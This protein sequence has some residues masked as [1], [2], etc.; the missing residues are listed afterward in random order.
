MR[1]EPANVSSEP[2]NE[3]DKRK[4][5]IFI[6]AP[7]LALILTLLILF[8]FGN[9]GSYDINKNP[10]VNIDEI[11]HIAKSATSIKSM[12]LNAPS[13]Q[14]GNT[15]YNRLMQYGNSVANFTDT[16]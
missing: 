7:L 16:K 4:I 14:T 8:S 3:K 12:D 6:L 15:V 2:D 9:Y 1:E 11:N 13:Y 5:L 10:R